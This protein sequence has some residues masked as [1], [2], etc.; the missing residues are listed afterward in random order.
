MMCRGRFSLFGPG[1]QGGHSAGCEALRFCWPFPHGGRK[2]EQ[3]QASQNNIPRAEKQNKTKQRT[4]PTGF[5]LLF[6]ET[7]PETQRHPHT[8]H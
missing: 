7:I 1:S 8:C 2:L 3:Y 4:L 5:S 6:P